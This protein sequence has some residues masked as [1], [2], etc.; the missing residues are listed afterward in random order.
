MIAKP[1]LPTLNHVRL[2]D[3]K[4]AEALDS[5]VTAIG[6][7]SSFVDLEKPS[8]TIN[9]ANT[10]FFLSAA[11]SPGSSLHLY[12]TAAGSTVLLIQGTDYTLSG[13]RVTL[14]VA[15]ANGS[16]LAASYRT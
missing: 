9:G 7:L 4:H 14:K 3:P 11:P 16:S 15:P 10:L 2:K 12:K 6:N 8:G 5:L 1:N 13:N